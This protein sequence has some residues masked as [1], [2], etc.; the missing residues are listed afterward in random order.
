MP[1]TA[2]I[3]AYAND[4]FAVGPSFVVIKKPVE[5]CEQIKK[6]M[7][8][9]IE[10][11]LSEVRAYQNPDAWRPGVNGSN[12]ELVVSRDS[13]WYTTTPHGAAYT[14]ETRPQDIASFVNTVMDAE[15]TITDTEED[16]AMLFFGDDVDDLEEQVEDD[17]GD[18]FEYK[19]YAPFD[20]CGSN[21]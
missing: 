3:E 12:D 13:F 18:D 14:V 17:D 9:C 16:G 21:S 19:P 2:Y 4:D 10:H 20:I 6:L 15:K 8:L 11:N 7:A 1:T 5:L